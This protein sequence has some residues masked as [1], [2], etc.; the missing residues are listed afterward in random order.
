MS[1]IIMSENKTAN[2]SRTNLEIVRST[3]EGSP[4]EL[5][6]A[7][8]RQVEWTESAG[9]PYGGTYYEVEA[10]VEHVFSRLSSEWIDFKP[11]VSV[12][13]EVKGKDIVIVEGTYSGTYKHTGKTFQ[14]DFVHV[15]ELKNQKIVKF[16]QYV[17]SHIIQQAMIV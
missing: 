2:H 12:Y 17:D 10:I 3:Y 6:E 5:I 9:Y 7:L 16:K 14:A 13:H 1:E 11:T 15:F 4:K 8:S